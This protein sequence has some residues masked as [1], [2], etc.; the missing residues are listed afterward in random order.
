[1]IH[2]EQI[3]QLILECFDTLENKE[4]LFIVEVRVQP[5]NIIQVFI[6]SDKSIDISDCIRVSRYIESK[7][8]R[9][10]EDFELNVSSYGLDQSIFMPRQFKKFINKTL[11]FVLNNNEDFNA[12]IN[13]VSNE[14]LFV[15]TVPKKKK[16][17]SEEKTILITE[18]NK[19]KLIITF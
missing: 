3:K 15:T 1:M 11:R 16:D 14:Q 10:I 19:A 2:A 13:A 18:I 17:I 4:E 5:G 12:K 9:E 6:D 8:D 7:L